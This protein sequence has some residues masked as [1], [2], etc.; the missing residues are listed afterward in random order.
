LLL[1]LCSALIIPQEIIIISISTLPIAGL[2]LLL[3]YAPVVLLLARGSLFFF[4]LFFVHVPAVN[5]NE[6]SLKS[7]YVQNVKF[8]FVSG[9]TSD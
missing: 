8:V 1:I 3:D 9:V 4:I 7:L 5:V 6:S 2:L